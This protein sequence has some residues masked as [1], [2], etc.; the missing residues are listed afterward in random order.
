MLHDPR[1]FA[2]LTRRM[3]NLPPQD[4]VA[5]PSLPELIRRVEEAVAA[6]AGRPRP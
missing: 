3:R 5:V 4:A 6:G 2:H 1:A